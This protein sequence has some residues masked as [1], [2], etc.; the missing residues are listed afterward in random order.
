MIELLKEPEDIY[1]SRAGEYLSSHLLIAF[2]KYP[3][4]YRAMITREYVRPDT[5]YYAFG[6]ALHCL[7][8]EGHEVFTS[9]YIADSP[10]NPATGKP[11]GVATKKYEVWADEQREIGHEPIAATQ[12]EL[13]WTMAENVLQHKEASFLLNRAPHRECVVRG[14]YCGVPC[15]IRMDAFGKDVGIIDFKTCDKLSRIPYAAK[16]YCYY[17][18]LAFYR[19]VLRAAGN[20]CSFDVH[21]IA[22]EKQ[23]PYRCGVWHV[24]EESLD[25]AKEDNELFISELRECT[26]SN[27]WPTR[28]EDI[29]ELRL[30]RQ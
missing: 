15:Q 11:F 27:T 5:E 30:Y 26:I 28:Y 22:S 21:L 2:A 8:L 4:L 3:I 24:A 6:R 18:Q 23:Y 7:V 13:V 20:D 12:I 17:E 14:Y 19:E 25:I 10:I 29:R 16:D 1:H 9:R